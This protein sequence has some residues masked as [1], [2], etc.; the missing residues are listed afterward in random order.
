[1]R[2]NPLFRRPP[3]SAYAIAAEGDEA[4]L[5]L[6]GEIVDTPPVDWFTGEPV[7]DGYIALSDFL[8]KLDELEDKRRVTVHIN[9]VGGDLISGVAIYNRLKALSGEVVTICDSLAA[10]AGSVIFQAGTVRQIYPSAAVMVHHALYPMCDMCNALDLRAAADELD[11]YDKQLINAY[12]E[13]TGLDEA[14][15][16][17]RMDAESWMVGQE[18]VDAGFADEVIAGEA[19]AVT[20]SSTPGVLNVGRLRVAARM[21]PFALP[22][23]RARDKPKLPDTD[24][25]KNQQKGNA[26]MKKR[27]AHAELPEEEQRTDAEL[28]EDCPEN[29]ECEPQRKEPAAEI[30]TVEELKQAYPDLVQQIIEEAMRQGA[31]EENA[32]LAE[33]E[34]IE[35]EVDDPE[36]TRKA[37][38]GEEDERV[39]AKA[40]LFKA[41]RAR[42]GKVSRSGI[43]AGMARETAASAKVRGGYAAPEKPLSD[44]DKAVNLMREAAQR[45]NDA[46][47]GRK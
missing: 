1:M 40:L 32:R 14:A 20:E 7:T 8:P 41:A 9:S 4:T 11:G 23:A 17:A 5:N 39:D 26:A 33:I 38:F 44:A 34:E 45:A 28:E 42:A 35:D 2:P 10:S 30:T 27:F 15:V 18:A 37:K 13:R 47:K 24:A 21:M 46:L 43:R 31:E 6:Y 29:E 3:L 22:A 25:P 36:E 16:R 12:I 19:P